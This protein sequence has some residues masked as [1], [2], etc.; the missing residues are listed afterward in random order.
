MT[1][2]AEYF[3]SDAANALRI[4]LP[5]IPQPPPGQGPVDPRAAFSPPPASA[6]PQTMGTMNMNAPQQQPQM[7][8]PGGPMMTPP[9]GMFPP[10][11]MPPPGFGPP[12][13]RSGG[14][15][16]TVLLVLVLMLLAI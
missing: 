6:A 16:K 14:A 7:P 13:R 15:G 12:P 9:P 2:R 3:W 1:V 8:M 5:M 11:M 4:E 10:M